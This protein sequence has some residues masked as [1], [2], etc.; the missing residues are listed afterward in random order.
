MK[1]RR[2]YRQHEWIATHLRTFRAQLWQ[3]I[4]R[5]HLND[6]QT[7]LPWEMAWDV[8]MMVPMLEMCAPGEIRFIPE[9]L[10]VYNEG[11]PI[12][13]HRKDVTKQRDMHQRILAL[14]SY[15]PAIVAAS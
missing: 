6:P 15:A 4:R 8:A 2:A 1:A 13:D 5:E 12:S 3:R 14:P 9:I 11:N 10:Y 7:G